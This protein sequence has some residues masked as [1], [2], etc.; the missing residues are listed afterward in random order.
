MHDS[1]TK[2]FT[3]TGYKARDDPPRKGCLNIIPGW[4][5]NWVT[6][7]YDEVLAKAEP[8]TEE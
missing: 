6:A 7:N 5:Y 3:R 8:Y 4:I 2:H 1:L